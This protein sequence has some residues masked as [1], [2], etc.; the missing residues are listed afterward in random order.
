MNQRPDEEASQNSLFN[1]LINN[2]EKEEIFQKSK[3]KD[4]D[5]CRGR[6]KKKYSRKKHVNQSFCS[7]FI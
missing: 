1:G 2:G 3:H 6:K 5:Q 4:N 7:Y